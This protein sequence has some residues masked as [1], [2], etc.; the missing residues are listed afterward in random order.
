M[1]SKI[2]LALFAVTAAA[3]LAAPAS[4]KSLHAGHHHPK[5]NT[6]RTHGFHSVVAPSTQFY[7]PANRDLANMNAFKHYDDIFVL[8]P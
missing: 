4:A 3:V 5:V 6:A 7:V 1:V 8:D 2:K